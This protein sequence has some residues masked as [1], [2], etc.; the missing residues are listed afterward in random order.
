[1]GSAYLGAGIVDTSVRRAPVQVKCV[2]QRVNF[3]DRSLG[4]Q[5]GGGRNLMPGCW[6]RKLSGKPGVVMPVC[7]SW[8]GGD[9]NICGVC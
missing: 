1:M 7:N 8:G 4:L 6:Y 3:R 5:E 2:G 9:G